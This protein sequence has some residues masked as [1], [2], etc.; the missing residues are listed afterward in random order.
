ML[1]FSALSEVMLQ[2]PT[3]HV[4]KVIFQNPP[5][6]YNFVPL[7]T[8]IQNYRTSLVIFMVS[9]DCKSQE[10]SNIIFQ[11]GVLILELVTGQSSDEGNS[12]IVEWIQE[13]CF[14]SS[15]EKMIDPDLGDDFDS[16]ELKKLLIVARL[17]IKTKDKPTFSVPQ[18][19]RYIQKKVDFPCQ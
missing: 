18:I 12:D 19:L 17:C 2:I 7:I 1:A 11:L 15:I 4:Q 9:A 8:S 13:S 16:R 6:S 3:T 10:C 14:R 5:G